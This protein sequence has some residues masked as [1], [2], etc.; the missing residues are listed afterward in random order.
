MD[1][2][3][4]SLARVGP[5][6]GSFEIVGRP[7]RVVGSLEMVGNMLGDMLDAMLGALEEGRPCLIDG[8]VDGARLI[9][10]CCET[11]GDIEIVGAGDSGQTSS[12]GSATGPCSIQKK[13]NC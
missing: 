1:I 3:G 8:L 10:G 7:V 4:C 6:V 12:R 2:V 13:M 9:D 5:N 11:E